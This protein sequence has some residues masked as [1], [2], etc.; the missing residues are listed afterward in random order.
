[1]AVGVNPVI[2]DEKNGFGKR[3]MPSLSNCGA[4]EKKER[5]SLFWLFKWL[6]FVYSEEN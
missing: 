3:E 4:H 2:I 1:M 6:G 5:N